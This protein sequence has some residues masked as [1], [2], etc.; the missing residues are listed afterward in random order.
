MQ[1]RPSTAKSYN[2]R[3]SENSFVQGGHFME[4][5]ST[6]T[7]RIGSLPVF[8]A[9]VSPV[10]A[11]R[12]P[13]SAQRT[14]MKRRPQSAAFFSTEP[15]TVENPSKNYFKPSMTRLL[16]ITSPTQEAKAAQASQVQ[17][18]GYGVRRS[19]TTF[20]T[21]SL[22]ILHKGPKVQGIT[23]RHQKALPPPK[24]KHVLSSQ[25]YYDVPI[26]GRLMKCN[27][28]KN[29]DEDSWT[30][31][32]RRLRGRN[33]CEEPYKQKFNQEHLTFVF[34]KN[35][36]GIWD[37]HDVEELACTN[38][39]FRRKHEES[40]S[41]R[42]TQAAEKPSLLP[43]VCSDSLSQTLPSSATASNM[44]AGQVSPPPI[45]SSTL[46]LPATTVHHLAPSPRF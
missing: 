16:N 26:N 2:A 24:G 6:S 11:E 19:P 40:A 23:K 33:K 37:H 4:T 35:H 10:K 39:E 15:V 20:Q 44:L 5:W 18:R 9:N 31:N 36:R 3:R 32:N 14:T 1:L 45:F 28:F 17:K 38:E 30:Y 22:P 12:R 46:S 8:I 21:M 25:K 41:A 7:S 29:P 43:A 13:Q 34:Y 42:V 27:S